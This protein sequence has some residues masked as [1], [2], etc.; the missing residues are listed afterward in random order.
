MQIFSIKNGFFHQNMC[1]YIF[2]ENFYA[3]YLN[4]MTLYYKNVVHTKQ[5][6]SHPTI[7]YLLCLFRGHFMS[8]VHQHILFPFI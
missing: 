7:F 1:I 6:L 4:F 5:I 3:Q 2:M 8:T